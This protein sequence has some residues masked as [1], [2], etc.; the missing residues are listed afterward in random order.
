MNPARL[1]RSAAFLNI[2]CGAVLAFGIVSS[3]VGLIV[4][5]PRPAASSIQLGLGAMLILLG[6]IAGSMIQAAVG[7]LRRPGWANARSLASNSSVILCLALAVALKSIGLERMIG[8]LYLAIAALVAFLV[9]R[10]V[11]QPLVRRLY[12]DDSGDGR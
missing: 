8:H 7:Y 4:S 1:L 10:L 2:A 12:P 3:I 5:P 6:I 9:H 11:L